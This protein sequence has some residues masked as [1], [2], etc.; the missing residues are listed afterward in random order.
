MPLETVRQLIKGRKNAA[1][2]LRWL[3]E[4]MIVL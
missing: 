2:A 3:V 1:E 4:A